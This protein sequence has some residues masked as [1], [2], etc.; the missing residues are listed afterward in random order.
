MVDPVITVYICTKCGETD[1]D[2]GTHGKAPIALHCA[3][4]GNG[5]NMSLADMLASGKGM[6]PE[7]KGGSRGRQ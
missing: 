6:F 7:V 2:S 5:Q 3:K 1:S 4:C